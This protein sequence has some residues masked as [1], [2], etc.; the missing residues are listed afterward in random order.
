MRHDG[1]EF[2]VANRQIITDTTA[3]LENLS[4][5]NVYQFRVKAMNEIGEGDPSK[6]ISANMQDDEGK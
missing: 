1:S 6:P 2:E 4:E 5:N 3:T